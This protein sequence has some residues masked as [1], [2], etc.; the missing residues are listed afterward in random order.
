MERWGAGQRNTIRLVISDEA[1]VPLYRALLDFIHSLG[2]A[3]PQGARARCSVAALAAPLPAA[4]LAT[5]ASCR[6]LL[7]RLAGA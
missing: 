6:S 5:V 4:A 3:L 1:E 7:P 2:R